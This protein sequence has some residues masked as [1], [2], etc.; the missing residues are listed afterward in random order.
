MKFIAKIIDS[1]GY[2]P[3][4]EMILSLDER[5]K[6]AR[7]SKGLSIRGL[8]RELGV[9]PK[10]IWSWENNKHKP[11]KELWDRLEEFFNSQSIKK[12]LI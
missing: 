1:R 11:T 6:I 9:D 4:D 5:I 7:Q 3:Y 10:T 12:D 8:A 2:V